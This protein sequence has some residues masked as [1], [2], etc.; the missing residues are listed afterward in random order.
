M[1]ATRIGKV[2]AEGYIVAVHGLDQEIASC[3]NNAQ[4]KLLGVGA[5]LRAQAVT[6]KWAKTFRVNLMAGGAIDAGAKFKGGAT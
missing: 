5:Q 6:P 2:S 3:L 4:L 1:R